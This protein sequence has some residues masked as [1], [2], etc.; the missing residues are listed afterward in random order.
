LAKDLQFTDWRE[1]YVERK[2]QEEK[3]LEYTHR[4]SQVEKIINELTTNEDLRLIEDL[5]SKI[6]LEGPA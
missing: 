1:D 6:E 3:D 4:E 5:E 2:K